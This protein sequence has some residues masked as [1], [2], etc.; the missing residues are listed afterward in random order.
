MK[1]PD[2]KYLDSLLNLKD[3]LVL[4]SRIKVRL[5]KTSLEIFKIGKS[6]GHQDLFIK[7]SLIY[8]YQNHMKLFD[9]QFREYISNN[10][11]KEPLE[12]IHFNQVT[13]NECL[14][15]L[16][17][18]QFDKILSTQLQMPRHTIGILFNPITSW[19]ERNRTIEQFKK[20]VAKRQNN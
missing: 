8:L 3:T 2:F 20:I 16:K 9:T 4:I 7:A 6:L 13:N 15:Y 1:T 14:N 11:G 19:D 10:L 18:K 5:W 12:V 17:E